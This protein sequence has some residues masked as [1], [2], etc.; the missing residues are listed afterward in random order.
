MGVRELRTGWLHKLCCSP[1]LRVFKRSLTWV[2]AGLFFF[3]SS[4]DRSSWTSC[5]HKRVRSCVS[6][7]ERKKNDGIRCATHEPLTF[8]S[9]SILC[10]MRTESS[11]VSSSFCT[12][13][14]MRIHLRERLEYGVRARDKR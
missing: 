7:G 12:C 6:K 1:S 10:C 11:V 4:S 8:S 3:F 9:V 2:S 14:R 13:I 5:N